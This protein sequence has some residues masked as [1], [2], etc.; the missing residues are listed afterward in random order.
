M[1]DL[2]QCYSVNVSLSLV[3]LHRNDRVD[4]GTCDGDR[5]YVTQCDHFLHL[6]V[7]WDQ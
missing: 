3:L 2:P 4:S 1:G 7:T 5:M 6:L